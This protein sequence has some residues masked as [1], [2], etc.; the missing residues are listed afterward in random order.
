MKTD[1][2][3]Q[4]LER[5]QRQRPLNVEAEVRFEYGN[6]RFHTC[7][8]SVKEIAQNSRA[9]IVSLGEVKADCKDKEACGIEIPVSESKCAPGS[10]CC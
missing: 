7:I 5:V 3:L 8:Q 10:G 2:A 6:K 1:K 9:L 4:I